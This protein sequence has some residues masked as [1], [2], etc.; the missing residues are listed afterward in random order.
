MSKGTVDV[1]LKRDLA[2]VKSQ[3]HKV[4]PKSN[5]IKERLAELDLAMSDL[6]QQRK[7]LLGIESVRAQ[8]IGQEIQEIYAQRAALG[9]HFDTEEFQRNFV[10]HGYDTWMS[11]EPLKWRDPVTQMPRLRLFGLDSSQLRLLSR[12]EGDDIQF[13]VKYPFSIRQQY[14]D[15]NTGLRSYARQ[16]LPW[17]WG[18][19][20]P[21]RDE[22]RVS[23][24]AQFVGLIPETTRE[25]ITVAQESRTFE[26]IYILAEVDKWSINAIEPVN[27]D[28]LVL[29]WSEDYPDQLW[30]IDSFDIT[31][32][33][34]TVRLSTG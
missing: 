13:S 4:P 25:K 33:E 20:S 26:A 29:G 23:A 17:R 14:V 24:T 34:N 1:S 19:F 8:Q 16:V 6:A 21:V 28:P 15:L 32:L 3:L 11:L 12:V 22:T 31:P 18:I 27:V 9:A 2:L 5:T 7:K 10:R 30:Y